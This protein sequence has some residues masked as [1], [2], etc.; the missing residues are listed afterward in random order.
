[1]AYELITFEDLLDAVAEELKLDPNDT[2]EINRIKR[3]INAAYLDHVV[4][5]K[6]WPWLTGHTQVE[7]KPYLANGTVSVTPDSTTITFSTAPTTSK[8]GYLFAVDSFSEVYQIASHTAGATTATLSSPWTGTLLSGVTYKVWTDQVVLPVDCRETVEVYHSFFRQPMEGVGLQEF[9]RR[10]AE[11]PFKTGRPEFYSTYDFV[12]EEDATR[13]RVMKVYPSILANSTTLSIDYVREVTPLDL[14]SDEPVMPQGDRV[15]LVYGALVRAWKRMRNPEASEQSRR[16]FLEKLAQM[17]G[18]VEDSQDNAQLTPSS[19]YLS[20]KRGRGVAMKSI[21]ATGSGSYSAPSY[22]KNPV[23]EGA[24]VTANITVNSGITIDGRDVSADG[25]TL[26][27]HIAETTDAHDASAISVTPSGGLTSTDVQGALQ[28]LQAEIGTFTALNDGNI[29]MGNASNEAAQV[30]VSG[31]LTI[32]NTGV[33]AIASGAVVN[34]DIN[35]SAAIE[36]S[37]MEALT[38][39]RAMVTDGAGE[40]SASSVT[41]TELGYVA[42]VT[43]A[44]QTQLNAKALDSDLTTVEGKIDDHIADTTAAHAASAISNTPSGNLS[45]T[46]VQAALN[47]LQTELDSALTNPMT[48]GGDIIYGGASGVVTR[49]A[50]GSASQV[51]Q[52]AGGTDAPTWGLE[53]EVNSWTPTFSNTTNLDAN[54]SGAVTR[55]VRIGSV[56]LWYMYFELDVTSS[57]AFTFQASL[58]VASNF[59]TSAQVIGT[60]ATGAGA[61]Y[62]RVLSNSTNDTLSFSGSTTSTGLTGWTSSGLYIII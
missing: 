46:D 1:M 38:A 25:A 60:A 49:L 43:S 19:R 50:N 27:A 4:P 9:R 33:A 62:A 30:T 6:R 5:F 11:E 31:D 2:V 26:D 52:S 48:T 10:V 18:R 14:D 54:P 7:H 37:K 23:I 58:P 29:F 41:A 56:V 32:D 13:Y 24:S 53:L 42:G 57:G 34:A 21:S 20:R 3:D 45:A 59:T 28:E 61:G 51:L 40:A 36:F 22:L 39:S 15:V 44:I 47:E 35:A 16:D 17:A 12:G 55:Y 8:T